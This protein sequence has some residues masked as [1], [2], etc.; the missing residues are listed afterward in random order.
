MLSP[1]LLRVVMIN[2]ELSSSDPGGWFEPMESCTGSI[3]DFESSQRFWANLNNYQQPPDIILVDINFEDDQSSPLKGEY[4][5]KPTGLLYAIPFLAWCRTSHRPTAVAFQTGDPGLFDFGAGVSGAMRALAIELA[6]LAASIDEGGYSALLNID[7]II[8]WRGFC[9]KLYE[10]GRIQE[11]SRRTLW[12][13]LPGPVQKLIAQA[14]SERI[15]EAE[16][17]RIVKSLN[18]MLKSRA[19]CQSIDVNRDDFIEEALYRLKHLEPKLPQ[20]EVER[21][22]RQVLESIF[23]EELKG[24]FQITNAKTSKRAF[25]WIVDRTKGNTEGALKAAAERFRKKLVQSTDA[26]AVENNPDLIIVDPVAHAS[27]LTYCTKASERERETVVKPQMENWPGLTLI[28]KDGS[29]D[30]ISVQSLFGDVLVLR[31][32]DFKTEAVEGRFTPWRLFKGKPLIGHYLERLAN[33]TRV[34]DLAVNNVKHLPRTGDPLQGGNLN[35]IIP[36]AMEDSNLVRFLILMFQIVRL[37]HTGWENWRK[38]Y[39]EIEWDAQNTRFQGSD[40]GQTLKKF[41]QNLYQ[42]IRARVNTNRREGRSTINEMEMLEI[43]DK[44]RRLDS[45]NLPTWAQFHLEILRSLGLI[46][47]QDDADGSE[48]FLTDSQR[49]FPDTVP[50]CPPALRPEWLVFNRRGEDGGAL[51]CLI[52][53]LGFKE[54]TQIERIVI[55]APGSSA[56]KTDFFRTLYETGR[57]PGWIR[58]LCQ[59]YAQD[60]LQWLEV[61]HWPQFMQQTTTMP[62]G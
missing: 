16:K 3:N 47:M 22:N 25:R 15:D 28:F 1:R 39:S 9:S 2:D 49:Q 19:F 12:A 40:S 57:A 46:G 60:Q 45:L 53:T 8:D 31:A 27:L 38:D 37:H 43:V 13:L 52:K 55:N 6:S 59:I 21:L 7:D 4:S 29:R 20:H 35:T 26:D 36:N 48:W 17:N 62:L 24:S 54:N 32:E 50:L 33:W 30:C 58:T 44:E 5:K 34:Y 10:Q 56:G 18:I 23:P 14:Q 11:G 61:A 42:K 41:L 51:K